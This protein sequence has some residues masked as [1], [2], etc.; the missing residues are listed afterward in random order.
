MYRIN[1][2]TKSENTS[3]RMNATLYNSK[4]RSH[5]SWKMTPATPRNNYWPTLIMFTHSDAY[6]NSSCHSA[7]FLSTAH[8]FIQLSRCETC[9]KNSISL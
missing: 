1:A 8:T 7:T 5:A 4:K 3:M 6:S 2:H 9:F